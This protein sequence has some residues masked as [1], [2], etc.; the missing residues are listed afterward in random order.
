ME[1][2]CTHRGI[3]TQVFMEGNED[4]R[5]ILMNIIECQSV[6]ISLNNRLRILI[7]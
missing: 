3:S 2:T 6:F 5:E 4:M 1:H 7:Q